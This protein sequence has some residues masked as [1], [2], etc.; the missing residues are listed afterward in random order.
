MAALVGHHVDQLDILR[1]EQLVQALMAARDTV[2]PGDLGGPSRVRVTQ[3]DDL[4]RQS[5]QGTQVQRAEPSR[6][7]HPDTQPVAA[8]L[9]HRTRDEALD[10][11]APNHREQ[12]DGG[13]DG[14][15]RTGHQ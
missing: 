5:G 15:D 9:L 3:R 10:E 4:H 2:P 8:H 14:E 6:P 7:D 1:V 12:D 13:Q 11:V